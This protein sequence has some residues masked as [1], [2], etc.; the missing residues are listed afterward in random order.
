MTKHDAKFEYDSKSQSISRADV[1]SDD[2]ITGALAFKYCFEDAYDKFDTNKADGLTRGELRS[3]IANEKLSSNERTTSKFLLNHFDLLADLK[4][5]W[6]SDEKT[7]SGHVGDDLAEDLLYQSRN[8]RNAPPLRF[9]AKIL[10][11]V[12]KFAKSIGASSTDTISDTGE[13]AAQIS[14]WLQDNFNK[15]D[16]NTDGLIDLFELRRELKLTD[17]RAAEARAVNGK[18]IE[19]EELIDDFGRAGISL[20]DAKALSKAFN[21]E[22]PFD[23][24]AVDNKSD[25]SLA[26]LAYQKVASIFGDTAIGRAANKKYNETA[27]T[28]LG[29]NESTYYEEKRRDILASGLL[30]DLNKPLR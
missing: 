15:L 20:D 18:T 21:A 26:T 10:P 2:I 1:P 3:A 28:Y 11:E 19:V 5:N 4:P 29:Q 9:D 17:E 13:R 30:T 27:L 16:T 6:Y 12:V 25:F 23:A 22:E 14:N 7:I 24:F 8:P